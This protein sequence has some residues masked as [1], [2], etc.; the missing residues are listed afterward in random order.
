MNPEKRDVL[1]HGHRV[2]YRVAGAE[3]GQG[4]P[5]LVLVHGM[6]GSSA[7]WRGVLAGIGDGYHVIAPDLLGHGNS[8]KPRHDYSLGAHANVLR[9][10][11]I[12]LGI[13]KAT[14]VG[15]S[16][17]GGVAMQLA[18]QHPDRCER[19]V[20]VSSGGLGP[21]VSWMLRALALPGVEYL[22]PVLF[23][24]F[25]RDAGNAISR[26]LRRLGLEAPHLEQEWR[27]YVS[28]TDPAKRHAFIST[29]R[30]VVDPR[31]QAVSAHDRLYLAAR[32]PTLIMWG[33]RDRIIPVEHAAAAHA[34]IP[35][36]RL[37][38]FDEA[39]HFPH[40]EDPKHFL[41][42]LTSFV[43]TTDPMDL[44][45]PEWRALLT[46]GRPPVGRTAAEAPR[47]SPCSSTA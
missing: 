10:L 9:D 15:Q 46:A 25:V 3:A 1:L 39:G 28:L 29:L 5:V 11:M 23:P 13:D 33:R 24:S 14:V 21:E 4:R 34:A 6:A 40:C 8:D 19:L 43:D 42:V 7:T 12:A 35:G 2:V 17:G 22:M 41:E 32:L 30:A 20:L 18:Y 44:D 26:G 47:S 38:L 31:G 27:G 37:V 16:L 36:S 45:E